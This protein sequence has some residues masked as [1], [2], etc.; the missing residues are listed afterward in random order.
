MRRD[1]HLGVA[2]IDIGLILARVARDR[3]PL[4]EA[5]EEAALAIEAVYRSEASA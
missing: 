3:A 4:I 1:Y 2:A 5:G